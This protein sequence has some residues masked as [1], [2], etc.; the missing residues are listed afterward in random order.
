MVHHTKE[1][2][3]RRQLI[4]SQCDLAQDIFIRA[5]ETSEELNFVVG[6]QVHRAESQ[7]P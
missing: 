6:I 5:Y 2:V 7:C 3:E 1:T 4:L